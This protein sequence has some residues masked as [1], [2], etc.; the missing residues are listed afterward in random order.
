MR[1]GSG[2]GR[3]RVKIGLHDFPDSG[4]GRVVGDLGGRRFAL[5]QRLAET[6]KRDIEAG[7]G[8]IALSGALAVAEKIDDGLGG[9]IDADR[10]AFDRVLLDAFAKKLAA[11][12]D[13]LQ[14]RIWTLPAAGPS[15]PIAIHT[16]CGMVSVSW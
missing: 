9:I 6:F 8:L 2:I 4:F 1:F 13:D 5:A 14:G 3:H 11:E 12:A 16:L 10:H 7:A 15:G